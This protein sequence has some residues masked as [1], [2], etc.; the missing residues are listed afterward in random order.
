[1]ANTLNRTKLNTRYGRS[2]RFGRPTRSGGTGCWQ[3]SLV[4]QMN[5]VPWQARCTHTPSPW[6]GEWVGALVTQIN[7]PYEITTA[8]LESTCATASSPGP[9]YFNWSAGHQ[10]WTKLSWNPANESIIPLVNFLKIL[11][12]CSDIIISIKGVFKISSLSKT[13]GNIATVQFLQ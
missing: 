7:K 6:T 9:V 2:S 8:L 12:S 13:S 1:M 11:L 3:N 4:H 5:P 10:L